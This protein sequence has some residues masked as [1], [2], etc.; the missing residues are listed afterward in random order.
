VDQR[1]TRTRVA[2]LQCRY[3]G[4]SFGRFQWKSWEC[5]EELE[6]DGGV[7]PTLEEEVN[8]QI[9]IP[10]SPPLPNEVGL[11]HNHSQD[12]ETPIDLNGRFVDERVESDLLV[13]A[14]HRRCD[15]GATLAAKSVEGRYLEQRA[16]TE[17]EGTRR[18][19]DAG[20]RR[21]DVRALRDGLRVGPWD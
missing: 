15:G 13:L 17:E 19:L 9:Q 6:G 14:I 4:L 12:L 7:A 10:R 18:A 11:E 21:N 3:A 8:E 5:A 20:W 2:S 1:G 16:Q